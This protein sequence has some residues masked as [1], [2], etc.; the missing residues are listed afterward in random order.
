MN[1]RTVSSRDVWL[2]QALSGT[3]LMVLRNKYVALTCDGTIEVKEL[4]MRDE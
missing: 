4:K 2:E 1:R 3:E